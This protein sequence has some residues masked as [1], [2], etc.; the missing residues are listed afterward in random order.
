MMAVGALW[1]RKDNLQR[2]LETA[3]PAGSDSDL[4]RY[5]KMTGVAQTLDS[6]VVREPLLNQ[7]C[8][9]FW[10]KGHK[11][12]PVKHAVEGWREFR[13]I[14]SKRSVAPFLVVNE[15]GS[16]LIEPTKA[17]MYVPFKDEHWEGRYR[18]KMASIGAGDRLTV[19]GDVQKL[20]PPMEGR[21]FELVGTAEAPLVV[22]TFTESEILQNVARGRVKAVVLLLVGFGLLLVSLLA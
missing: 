17:R 16:F 18:A 22:T 11:Y 13:P 9:W 5:V 2:A 10:I 3:A 21:V 20:H 12:L 19:I 1:F 14:G 15:K 8:A 6:V 4:N 7:P